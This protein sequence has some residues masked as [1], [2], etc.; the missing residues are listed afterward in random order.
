[1]DFV[2]KNWY[3][4]GEHEHGGYVNYKYECVEQ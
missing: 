3:E 2:Q 4:T 1:M